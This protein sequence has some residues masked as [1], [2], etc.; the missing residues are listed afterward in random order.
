MACSMHR[1]LQMAAIYEPLTTLG[2]VNTTLGVF[3]I[4]QWCLVRSL[5][6]ECRTS[7]GRS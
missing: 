4:E 7:D 3:G 1:A 2:L 6:S 5:R